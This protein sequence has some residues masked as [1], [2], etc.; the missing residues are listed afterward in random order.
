MGKKALCG[1]FFF[2]F[3]LIQ[4][5]P[6]CETQ[7]SALLHIHFRVQGEESAAAAVR[8]QGQSPSLKCVMFFIHHTLLCC[9]H[10]LLV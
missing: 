4:L 7:Q 10:C 9:L 3:A 5:L 6:V 2:F 1:F 8:A